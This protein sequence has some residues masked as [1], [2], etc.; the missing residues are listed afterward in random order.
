MLGD[1]ETIRAGAAARTA[2]TWSTAHQIATDT[3][4]RTYANRFVTACSS[5]AVDQRRRQIC[6]WKAADGREFQCTPSVVAESR[7]QNPWVGLLAWKER[8][9]SGDS[10]PLHLPRL[11]SRVAL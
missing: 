11:R 6:A 8:I 3:S 5:E 9:A 7:P 4:A 10:R 1:V 2:T